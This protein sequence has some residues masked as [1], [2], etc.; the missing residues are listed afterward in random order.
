MH[1]ETHSCLLE[2]HR[3]KVTDEILREM[4]FQLLAFL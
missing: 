4:P 3:T 2:M 1:K